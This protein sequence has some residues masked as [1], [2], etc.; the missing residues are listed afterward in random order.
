MRRFCA[1]MI[2]GGYSSKLTPRAAGCA[3]RFPL[4][5]DRIRSIEERNPA[6]FEKEGRAAACHDAGLPP[7]RP[8]PRGRERWYL[9]RVPEGSEAA[10]CKKLSKL[11]P[12]ELLPECFC[13][14][15]ERWMKKAGSWSLASEPARAGYAIAVT[16]DPAALASRLSQSSVPAQLAGS[17]GNAWTPLSDDARRWLASSMDEER[18]LRNS[19][20]VISDGVLKVRDGPLAGQEA[21]VKWIDRHRRRCAVKVPDAGSSF[22]V[23]MPIEVPCK[24]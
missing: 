3:R 14:R 8:T 4:Q 12:R 1:N 24:S 20:A 2:P 6:P 13:P 22:T 19:T 23:L 18:V 21:L 17:N 5:D 7:D 9:L 10:A 11:I 16:S 15:K